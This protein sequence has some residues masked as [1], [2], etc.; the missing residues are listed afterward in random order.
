MM[1]LLQQHWAEGNVDTVAQQQPWHFMSGAE[2]F[3]PKHIR[4]QEP[5]CSHLFYLLSAACTGRLVSDFPCVK[6]TSVL[7]P[8]A[9]SVGA[10]C[11]HC[12]GAQGASEHAQHCH[13]CQP[14][15][16]GCVRC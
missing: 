7:K 13:I 14:R 8:V 6:M 3:T 9:Y 10:G 11:L 4:F 12:Q 1:L 2:P 5:I 15:P 16:V